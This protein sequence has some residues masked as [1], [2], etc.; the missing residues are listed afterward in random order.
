MVGRKG[1]A[2]MAQLLRRARGMAARDPFVIFLMVSA[3]VFLLYWAV[4]LRGQTIDVP[5]S[6]QASLAEDYEM[7]TGHKPD[8]KARTKL[9]DDYVAD[10]V[11]FR[12]AVDRGMHL[13]D[14]T[15]RQ[16]LVDRVRFLIAGAPPEPT[17]EQLINH[18]AEH[19][20]LYRSEARM[21][22]EHVFFEKP[23]ADTPGILARLRRGDTIKGDDF[24]M[25]RTLPNYGVSMI[26][27]MFGQPFVKAIAT[28]SPG[29]WSGPYTS[30]RGLHFVRITGRDAPA[31]M[32]YP[33]VREQVRQDYIASESGSL[34]DDEVAKLE[35][36]YHVQIEN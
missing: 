16:R 28:A 17:E 4:S 5:V 2:L 34:V 27:G 24:W 13:T 14:R 3:A 7:M 26:R 1:F 15:T 9:I 25:G 21:T 19:G 30:S 23:P 29:E 36:G 12:E 8:Q 6:V 18:Y 22:L 33:A 20:E 11:L 10:E 32:P 35:K 31:L